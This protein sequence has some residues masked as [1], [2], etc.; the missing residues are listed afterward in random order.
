MY[1]VIATLD[2]TD[3]YLTI[4]MAILTVILWAW[5]VLAPAKKD[6][7]DEN[8]TSLRG[9]CKGYPVISAI[10]LALIFGYWFG[11]ITHGILCIFGVI[12][13]VWLV[14]IPTKKNSQDENKT[15]IQDFCKE[16]PVGTAIAL[17]IFVGIMPLILTPIIQND[18]ARNQSKPDYSV[19]PYPGENIDDIPSV[20]PSGKNNNWL[21]PTQTD[22]IQKIKRLKQQIEYCKNQV[23]YY[24]SLEQEERAKDIANPDRIRM[25]ISMASFFAEKRIEWE[26][27][28]DILQLE[29]NSL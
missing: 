28:R 16:R 11:F 3:S 14:L 20:R 12:A 10:V 2:S 21:N 26:G 1:Q 15:N 22:S 23:E 18:T 13:W 8:K 19:K 29:L 6:P 17:A 9:S 24:S 4:I 25:G 7:Q 27:H 5:L